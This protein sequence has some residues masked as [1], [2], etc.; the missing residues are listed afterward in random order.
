[1]EHKILTYKCKVCGKEIKSLYQ[2]QLDM[3]IKQHEILHSKGEK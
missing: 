1:M 3:N 2:K